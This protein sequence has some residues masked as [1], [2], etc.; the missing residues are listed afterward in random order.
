MMLKTAES[1]NDVDDDDFCCMHCVSPGNC[2]SLLGMFR[3]SSLLAACLAEAA[4]AGAMVTIID[5]ARPLNRSE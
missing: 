3:N 2:A 4:K 1:I 5:K